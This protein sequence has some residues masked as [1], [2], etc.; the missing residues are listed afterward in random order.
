MCGAQ[1]HG[2][3]VGQRRRE[4][5]GVLEGDGGGQSP[6]VLAPPV[7][8]DVAVGGDDGV[9]L[10]EGDLGVSTILGD[11]LDLG[12]LPLLRRWTGHRRRLLAWVA[13]PRPLALQRL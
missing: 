9:G 11:D 5:V 1:Y 7:E 8:V 12:L 6:P 13:L 4:V 3:A 2:R 10:V